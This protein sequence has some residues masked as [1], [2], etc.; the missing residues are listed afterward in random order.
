MT[1]TSTNTSDYSF[2]NFIGTSTST[3]IFRNC[4]LH[5]SGVHYNVIINLILSGSEVFCIL[6]T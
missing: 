6:F 5:D 1:S 2:R 3:V 4:Y